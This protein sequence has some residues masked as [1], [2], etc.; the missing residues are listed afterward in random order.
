MHAARQISMSAEEMK[1]LE[2]LVRANTVS[3]RLARRATTVL[4]AAA[5]WTI[6]AQLKRIQVVRRRQR[7]L[8][9]KLDGINRDL[10]RRGRKPTVVHRRIIGLATQSTPANV[11][12]WS[13]RIMA[14]KLG[15]SARG[16]GVCIGSSRTGGDLQGLPRF[17]VC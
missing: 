9:E 13:A 1:A 10:P 4:L 7:Y 14:A 3:V 2:K 15:V 17:A 8:Q 12:Q 6:A 11:T 5:I 16:V